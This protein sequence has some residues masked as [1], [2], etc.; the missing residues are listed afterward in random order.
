M[1]IQFQVQPARPNPVIRRPEVLPVPGGGWQPAGA[2][3]DHR[4]SSS[5]GPA[6]KPK[7]EGTK[8]EYYA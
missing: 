5:Q 4:A 1:N 3:K 7:H 6:M 8:E 2:R